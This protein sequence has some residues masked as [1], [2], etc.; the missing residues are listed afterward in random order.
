MR[1]PLSHNNPPPEK[2]HSL[3]AERS[4]IAE[5]EAR[6]CEDDFVIV[7]PEFVTHYYLPGRAPFRNLSDLDPVEATAAVAELSDLSK[8]GKSSRAFGPKYLALRSDTETVVRTQTLV[9]SVAERD[10][11]LH[12]DMEIGIEQ[13]YTT[14]ERMIIDGIA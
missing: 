6:A 1:P 12:S 11:W 14:L 3:A 8:T 7:V 13:G 10:A 2:T 4:R 9:G 5:V